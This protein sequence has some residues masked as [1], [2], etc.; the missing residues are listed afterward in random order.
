M[1][2]R[3]IPSHASFPWSPP[4]TSPARGY[5]CSPGL[6][7]SSLSPHRFVLHPPHPPIVMAPTPVDPVPPPDTPLR[8]QRECARSFCPPASA[9]RLTR[10]P[11]PPRPRGSAPRARASRSRRTRSL[12][13]SRT[14]SGG[15]PG[16]PPPPPLFPTVAPILVPTV[17]SHPPSLELLDR[18]LLAEERIFDMSRPPPPPA[19]SRRW[20]I[21]KPM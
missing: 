18:S 3:P 15:L 9:S 16:V 8:H 20:P 19:P 12:D 17:H 14:S 21:G 5:R 11:P 4:L 10:S 7:S 1:Q 2:E 6:C 13:S